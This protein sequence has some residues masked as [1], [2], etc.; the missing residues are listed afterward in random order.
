LRHLPKVQFASGQFQTFFN[1]LEN[2]SPV[3]ADEETGGKLFDMK[4]SGFGRVRDEIT[5]GVRSFQASHHVIFYR[6]K[7]GAVEIARV[8]HPSMDVARRFE[9]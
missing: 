4:M 7:A 3:S 6:G 9:D 1:E 5:A 2:L 8:L